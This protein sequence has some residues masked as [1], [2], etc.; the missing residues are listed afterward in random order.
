MPTAATHTMDTVSH[1]TDATNAKAKQETTWK[2]KSNNSCANSTMQRKVNAD[3]QEAFSDDDEEEEALWVAALLR[4]AARERHKPWGAK[5]LRE[6]MAG[7]GVAENLAK[8]MPALNKFG[9]GVAEAKRHQ[10]ENHIELDEKGYRLDN[11]K[12]PL[13]DDA[14]IDALADQAGQFKKH[15]ANRAQREARKADKEAFGDE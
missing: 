11:G 4:R 2:Q 3:Q 14:I 5:V 9:E 8:Y 6:A 12:H 13:E 10:R 1:T 7:G 15:E